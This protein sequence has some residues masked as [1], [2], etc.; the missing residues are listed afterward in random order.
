MDR[1]GPWTLVAVVDDDRA[2]RESLDSLLRSAGFRV[3]VF[4]SADEFLASSCPQHVGCLILDAK[5][6]GM[7]G[8]DLQR[9][10][11]AN[12]FTFPVIFLSAEAGEAIKSRAL[13]AAAIAFL[14]KP[15]DSDLLLGWVRTAVAR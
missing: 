2:V 1:W 6:P 3:E 15:C 13:N 7:S 14:R 11:V 12:G 8:L 10:L 9:H 5:L 4:A